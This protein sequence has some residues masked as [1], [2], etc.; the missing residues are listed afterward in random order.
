MLPSLSPRWRVAVLA[1]LAAALLAAP[2]GAADK[3]KPGG[4]KPAGD[5]TR[6]LYGVAWQ[7]TLDA[8]L[9]QAEGARVAKPILLLQTLG[10][11]SG[12]M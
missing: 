11:P 8:A 2:A 3:A 10:E 9:K 5:A 1:A 4:K 6:T 12:F 7:P